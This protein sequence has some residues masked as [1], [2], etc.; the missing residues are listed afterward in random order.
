MR[1][2]RR[3]ASSR[4]RIPIHGE[5][6][7]LRAEWQYS[8]DALSQRTTGD[9]RKRAHGSESR[10]R[11]PELQSQRSGTRWIPAP[12][13]DS[14]YARVERISSVPVVSEPDYYGRLH[15]EQHS[16]LAQRGEAKHS[17]PASSARDQQDALPAL[18]RLPR[19]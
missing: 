5:P 7:V 4:L 15:R 3:S 16:P 14:L 12:L 2:P 1:A 8:S 6:C 13:E 9:A 19:E 10:S 11:K 18:S 17:E